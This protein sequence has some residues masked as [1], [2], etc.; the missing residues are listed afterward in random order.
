MAFITSEKDIEYLALDQEQVVAARAIVGQAKGQA[1]VISPYLLPCDEDGQLENDLLKD[2]PLNKNNL[3]LSA[4]NFV[5]QSPKI[6]Y[7]VKCALNSIKYDAG[8]A[9]NNSEIGGQIIYLD[10]GKAFKYGGS[11]YNAYDLIKRYLVDINFSWKDIRTGKTQ[12]LKE[13]DIGI[14]TGGMTQKVNVLDDFGK[15]TGEK[16][17]IREDIRDIECKSQII[18]VRM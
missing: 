10:R 13:E 12:R 5:E 3:S 4:K 14:I 9:Q 17:G 15:K 8:N 11:V 6:N 18:H 1:C 16:I 7:A 2:C